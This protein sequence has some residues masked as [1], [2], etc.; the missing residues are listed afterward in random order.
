MWTGIRVKPSWKAKF[1]KQ[2]PAWNIRGPHGFNFVKFQIEQ[3]PVRKN[4]PPNKW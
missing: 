3:K 1:V 2:K 4:I